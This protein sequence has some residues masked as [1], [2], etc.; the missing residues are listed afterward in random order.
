MSSDINRP[1]T[2]N[3]VAHWF[4]ASTRS[5]PWKAW[6]VQF[7]CAIFGFHFSSLWAHL[8]EFSTYILVGKIR[9]FIR[10]SQ[11]KLVGYGAKLIIV[12]HCYLIIHVYAN[13]GILLFME[14][15]KADVNFKIQ[16]LMDQKFLNNLLNVPPSS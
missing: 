13:Q 12:V 14:N 16:I 10:I 5:E 8:G 2:N 1:T 7:T 11:N 15:W 6:L 3:I 9:L 4:P